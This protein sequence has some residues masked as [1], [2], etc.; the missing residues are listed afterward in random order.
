MDSL[1]EALGLSRQFVR[2]LDFEELAF[3]I[4]ARYQGL[5]SIDHPDKGGDAD[6]FAK[7]NEAQE[8]LMELSISDRKQLAREYARETEEEKK[9]KQLGRLEQVIDSLCYGTVPFVSALAQGRLYGDLPRKIRLSED[10]GSKL[11]KVLGDRAQDWVDVSSILTILPDYSVEINRKGAVKHYPEKRIIGSVVVPRDGESEG[12]L[13]FR[14]NKFLVQAKMARFDDEEEIGAETINTKLTLTKF[15]EGVLPYLRPGILDD[16]LLFSANFDQNVPYFMLEGHT[17]ETTL[18]DVIERTQEGIEKVV[19]YHLRN[20][21]SDDEI[22]AEDVLELRRRLVSSDGT[23][24]VTELIKP[25]MAGYYLKKYP[26]LKK[27]MPKSGS[28]I[29]Y[30]IAMDDMDDMLGARDEHWEDI[31][32]A[33]QSLAEFLTDA[34]PRVYEYETNGYGLTATLIK[35]VE[36]V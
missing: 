8:L 29:A 36:S 10:Y 2:G 9:R 22:T 13:S 26:E 3:W 30:G 18:P 34:D 7:E 16:A 5:A 15:K 28:A 24:S 11:Q 31:T 23:V 35:D 33:V 17:R 4:K 27:V 21:L 6:A 1:F 14:F 12:D 19:N 32:N 25:I 20:R